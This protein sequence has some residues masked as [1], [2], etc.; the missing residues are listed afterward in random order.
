MTYSMFKFA[1]PLT[2]AL[3]AVSG[4]TAAIAAANSGN[5]GTTKVSAS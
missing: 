5:T 4:A 2:L 3:A 1:L